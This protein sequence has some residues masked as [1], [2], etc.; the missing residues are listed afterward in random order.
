M[1]TK[2]VVIAVDPLAHAVFDNADV[3]VGLVSFELPVVYFIQVSA[4]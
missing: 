1:E 4:S 2:D 3:F